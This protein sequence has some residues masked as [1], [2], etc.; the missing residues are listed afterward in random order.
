[1][2]ENTIASEIL[3]GW[4][5]DVNHFKAAMEWLTFEEQQLRRDAWLAERTKAA[6]RNFLGN[7]R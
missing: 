7:R 6:G 1:M 5:L 2:E 4:R 3:Y